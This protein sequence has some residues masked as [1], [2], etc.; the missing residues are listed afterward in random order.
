MASVTI[1]LRHQP[2]IEEQPCGVCGA[3]FV[4]AED[5]GSRVLG[6]KSGAQEFFFL[7]CGGWG[8]SYKAE[9]GRRKR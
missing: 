8:S 2:A 7:I 6:L 4:P 1:S 5:S 3:A 9:F